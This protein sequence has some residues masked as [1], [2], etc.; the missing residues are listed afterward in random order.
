MCLKSSQRKA[1]LSIYLG[2]LIMEDAGPLLWRS[3]RNQTLKV[4]ERV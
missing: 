2:D 4:R 1:F 3:E